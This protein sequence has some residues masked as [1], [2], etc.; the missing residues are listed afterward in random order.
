MPDNSSRP[1]TWRQIVYKSQQM[2]SLFATTV[3]FAWFAILWIWGSA[4]HHSRFVRRLF[5]R[6]P[7]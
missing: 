5:H 1:V 4:L 7:E 3:T 6:H 2:H